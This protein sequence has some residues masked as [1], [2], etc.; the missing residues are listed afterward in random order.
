MYVD[1]IDH[2]IPT[3]IH[4]WSALGVGLGLKYDSMNKYKD[5]EKSFWQ[6]NEGFQNAHLVFQNDPSEENVLALNERKNRKMYEEKVE[7]IIVR[8]RERCHEHG[9]KNFRYFLNLEKRDHI[10]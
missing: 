3:W 7:G 9:E 8:S 1:E 6:V 10:S 5:K 4:I 2:L